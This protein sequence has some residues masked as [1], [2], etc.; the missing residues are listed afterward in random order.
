MEHSKRVKQPRRSGSAGESANT[1]ILP[2]TSALHGI[3]VLQDFVYD[4]MRNGNNPICWQDNGVWHVSYGDHGE[5]A[6][7]Y[8]ALRLLLPEETSVTFQEASAPNDKTVIAFPHEFV[9]KLSVTMSE[10]TQELDHV[11]A[12]C[13]KSLPRG[14]AHYAQIEDRMS[15]LMLISPID[16]Q[17]MERLRQAYHNMAKPETTPSN[18][19]FIARVQLAVDALESGEPL[20]GKT[21]DETI[22]NGILLTTM[23]KVHEARGESLANISS[24]DYGH[25]TTQTIARVPE[26]FVDV[27]E[28]A[29]RGMQRHFMGMP[30]GTTRVPPNPYIPEGIQIQR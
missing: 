22:F 10:L 7:T 8:R 19:D 4:T 9:V 25:Y 20:V 27:A 2:V 13:E 5:A 26:K 3:S 28:H 29:V 30:T 12:I 18:R 14:K 21:K 1:L 15:R 17:T 6:A 23:N 16:V 11:K 24:T